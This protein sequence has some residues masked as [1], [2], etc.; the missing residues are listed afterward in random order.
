M[1]RFCYTLQKKYI[2]FIKY[3]TSIV[4]GVDVLTFFNSL[5][6]NGKFGSLDYYRVTSGII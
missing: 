4:N 5:F 2:S 3:V 6:F 1:K